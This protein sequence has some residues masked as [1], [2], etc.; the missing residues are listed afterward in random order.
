[1]SHDAS[2]P[3][4]RRGGQCKGTPNKR[5]LAGTEKLEALGCDPIE[6][7]ARIA[8]DETAELSIRQMYKELAQYVAAKRKAME[9]QADFGQ[10]YHEA[11]KAVNARA[12]PEMRHLNW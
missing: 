10:P 2:K 1:M 9:M 4:E 6:G 11:L 12:K 3:G 8:M 7:I 5:T